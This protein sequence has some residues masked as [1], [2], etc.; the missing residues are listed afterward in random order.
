MR[1]INN[2]VDA[3]NYILIERGQPLHAF[4]AAKISGKKIIVRTAVAGEEITTLDGISHKLN[5]SM[6]VIA[7][8]V[9]PVAIAGIM[10]G[11][12]TEVSEATVD[13][14]LE[15][16]FFNPLSVRKTSFDL[17][18]R[19]EASAHFEKGIDYQNVATSLA[20]AVAL[21]QEEAGGQIIESYIEASDEKFYSPKT[22]ILRK[23]RV[24]DVLGVTIS[25]KDIAEILNFLGFE[26][27]SGKTGEFQVVVPSWRCLD[28]GR[29]ID[30]IEEI[31]RI[32]G[33]DAV[34]VTLPGKTFTD[35][36]NPES[37]KLIRTIRD[38]LA[39]LGFNDVYNFSL[40]NLKEID[41]LNLPNDHPWRYPIK[42]QN[43]LTKEQT[44]LYPTLLVGLLKNLVFNQ[45]RQFKEVALFEVNN[46]F[47]NTANNRFFEELNLAVAV[48]G[49]AADFFELK[50]VLEN[51]FNT[52]RIYKYNLRPAA[53]AFLTPGQSAEVISEAGEALGYIGEITPTAAANF[54]LNSKVLVF[55]ISLNKAFKLIEDKKYFKPLP[56]FPAV[57]RD[58]AIIIDKKFAYQEV[59]K[60]IKTA[61]GPLLEK[62]ELFDKYEGSQIPGGSVSLAISLTFRHPERTLLDTEVNKTYQKI[63]KSLEEKFSSKLR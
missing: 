11:T 13:V 34:P 46:V 63:V 44:L 1:P 45:N 38:V 51:V 61:G 19:T 59:V 53:G 4:D 25:A 60:T 55:E 47:K 17:G 20:E 14:L 32:Y 40:G 33:Y 58:I 29:E 24:T 23:K 39:T 26:V 22:I 9:R 10:G 41:W 37:E 52:I 36:E 30:L 56:R 54:G 21:I 57:F 7:D 42:I 43:S 31:I 6:L 35:I 2:V 5:P 62:A 12:N 49:P 50:G 27:A 3:T 28:V 48:M 18:L 8:A 15:A 16:A